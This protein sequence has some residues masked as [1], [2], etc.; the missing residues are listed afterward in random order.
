LYILKSSDNTGTF[1]PFGQ[2]GDDPSIIGDYDGDGKA[3]PAIYRPGATA[4]QQ[5][6]FYYRGSSNNPGGNITFVPW[7]LNGDV[8][9]RGDYDAD[10]RLDLTVFRPLNGTWYSLHLATNT[11]TAT[12][13]GIAGDRIVPADYTGDGKTDHAIFRNGVWY[14]LESEAGVPRYASW[15]ITT[16]RLVPA[17][18]DGDGRAD[19]A[20]YRDGIWYMQ[21]STAGV[22]II[23]FGL[24]TDIPAPTSYLP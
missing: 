7:G 21:R 23:P 6:T 19:V 8:P 24:S 2:T 12:T 22:A 1:I 14:I 10:G 5:S 20:V 9:A 16:D 11:S 4:G 18:Y 13:W 15:G 17:D 3:D